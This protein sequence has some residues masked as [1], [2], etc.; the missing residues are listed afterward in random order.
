[1]SV[2][3]N[4]ISNTEELQGQAYFCFDIWWDIR[5]GV[6]IFPLLLHLHDCRRRRTIAVRGVDKEMGKGRS[7][8]R[9]DFVHGLGIG[10][11]MLVF[12][13]GMAAFTSDGP[14]P[15]N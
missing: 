10:G 3:F 1:M 15:V 6:F 8:T 13:L 12:S 4:Q 9:R 14:S 7:I 11:T 2:E 5:N